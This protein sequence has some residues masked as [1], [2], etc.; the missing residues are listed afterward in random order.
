MKSL[1]V[2]SRGQDKNNYDR[3]QALE[4]FRI[5]VTKSNMIL[6]CHR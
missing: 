2:N 4:E 1:N 5:I 3:E 6:E